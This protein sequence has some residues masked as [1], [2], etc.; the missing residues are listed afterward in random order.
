MS[1]FPSHIEF[2]DGEQYEV[3]S[4][5]RFHIGEKMQ[6]ADGRTFRYVKAGAVALVKGNL[7]Q[8]AANIA[9]HQAMTPTAAAVGA[10][11]VTVT[12]GATAA[13]ANQYQ[14]GWLVI[15]TGTGSPHMYQIKEHP[16]ADASATLALTLE[17]GVKVAI[18]ATASSADLITNPYYSVIVNPTSPTGVPIGVA[19]GTVAIGGFGWAQ[20]GGHGLV[21]TNGTVVLGKTVVPSLTTA[22]AVDAMALTEATPNTGSDQPVVGVVRKVGASTAH[23]LVA[24]ALEPR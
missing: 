16:A 4:D 23:S 14:G 12:L 20:T 17:L 13:T 15:R 10:R 11:E 21:L 3:T 22:G 19:C 8:S 9:N 6:L 5:Q 1:F 7:L 18:P 2:R 24:L